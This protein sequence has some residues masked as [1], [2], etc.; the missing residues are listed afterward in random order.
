MTRHVLSQIN[1]SVVGFGESVWLNLDCAPLCDLEEAQGW[2]IWGVFDE[3]VHFV[4]GGVKLDE[5]RRFEIPFSS[6]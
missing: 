3:A 5:N 2:I 6:F 4:S 1:H